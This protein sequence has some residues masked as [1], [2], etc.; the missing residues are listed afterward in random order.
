MKETIQETVK[1]VVNSFTKVSDIVTEPAKQRMG[2]PFIGSFAISWIF[3]NWKPIAYFIMTTSK[4]EDRISYIDTHFYHWNH[5]FAFPLLTA[6]F[7]TLI[8]KWFDTFSDEFN[9]IP[10]ARKSKSIADNKIEVIKNEIRIVKEQRK[11]EN[12]KADN[13]EI[14]D[15]NVEIELLTKEIDVKDE[16]IAGLNQSLLKN[17]TDLKSLE[18]ESN[19]QLDKIIDLSLKLD[20]LKDENKESKKMLFGIVKEVMPPNQ[21]RRVIEIFQKTTSDFF[22]DI[23]LNELMPEFTTN[24][25]KVYVILNKSEKLIKAM[26][27]SVQGID[28]RI[29]INVTESKTANG[30]NQVSINVSYPE[31]DMVEEINVVIENFL[32]I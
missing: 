21:F 18:K 31:Q 1:E 24:Y 2:H 5:L 27:K 7:Y 28:P 14:Q 19:E 10:N 23:E 17:L 26:L 22:N 4:V 30:Q 25:N 32:N 15:L 8:L 6:V 3:F 20:T 11:L 13:K 16:Q 9:K 29:K 12:E